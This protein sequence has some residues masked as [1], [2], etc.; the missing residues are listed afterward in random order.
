MP[1]LICVIR[2]ALC[3]ICEG[4]F[5]LEAGEKPPDRCLVCGSPDWEFGPE[6]ADSRL[7][8]QGIDRLRK[9]LNPGAKSRKRQVRGSKQWRQF[10]PKPEGD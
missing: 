4:T 1:V 10:K 8:R 3:C 5:D 2:R 9:S 6:S 7:I